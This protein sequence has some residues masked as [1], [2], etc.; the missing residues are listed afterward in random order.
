M[1][2]CFT[3]FLTSISGYPETGVLLFPLKDKQR[4][5][6][7]KALVL[8]IGYFELKQNF[9]SKTA[10]K[11]KSPKAQKPKRQKDKK[12]KSMVLYYS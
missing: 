3:I 5:D 7:F 9:K 11:P 10:K 2:R 8:G 4:F 6:R 12:T 1:G